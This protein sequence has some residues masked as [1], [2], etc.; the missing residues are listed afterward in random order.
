[1]SYKESTLQTKC[2][3]HLKRLRIYNINI[4]GAGRSGKGAPDV[5]ACINGRFV[6]FEFKI[7]SNDMQ[8]DQVIHKRRIT[9]NGGLHFVPRSLEEFQKIVEEVRADEL[10]HTRR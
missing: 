3:Q 10:E 4:Y 9:E 1:M 7:G 2:I 8:S 5:I 6:A